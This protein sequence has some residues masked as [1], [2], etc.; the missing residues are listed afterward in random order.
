MK[1]TCCQSM[2]QIRDLLKIKYEE[3]ILKE[4]IS[5]ERFTNVKEE[6]AISCK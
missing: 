5:K 2:N 1:L 6:I 4:N 3:N